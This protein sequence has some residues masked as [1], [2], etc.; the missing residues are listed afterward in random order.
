MTPEQ[1]V[2]ERL[3]R[4]IERRSRVQGQELSP[5]EREL[6]GLFEQCDPEAAGEAQR[7]RSSTEEL[8][9]ELLSLSPAERLDPRFHSDDLVELLLD[10]SEAA[11]VEDP[12]STIVW[13]DLALPITEAL[14]DKRWLASN[15]KVQAARLKGNA[16]RLQGDLAQAEAAFALAAIH[17]DDNSLERP[18]F[19][20]SLG[21]LRWEQ[22]RLDEAIGLFLHAGALFHAAGMGEE[23]ATTLL[24]LG[25]LYSETAFPAGGLLS[26][27][28]GFFR[29]SPHRHPWLSLC[30]GFALASHLGEIEQIAEGRDV[31]AKAMDLY[32]LVRKERC[33]LQGCRWE[34]AARVRLGESGQAEQLLEGVRRRHL[35]RR[36]LPE[37]ALTSL[38]LGAVLVEL[39]RPEEIQRLIEEIDHNFPT[40][41]GTTLAVQALQAFQAGTRRGDGARRS[42]SWAASDFRRLFRLLAI[43]LGPIPFT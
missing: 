34:G 13:A 30:S 15:G 24:L 35:A 23:E 6:L 9:D 31:L 33:L 18:W 38:D 10:E 3:A 1:R 37:L 41:Q 27:Y 40:D 26:L 29:A 28:E 17:L 4:E 5:G 2:L 42:A 36:D 22:H 32:A 39:G 11:Q 8:R 7:R 16:W 43:P 12:E 14:R 19:C 21:V 20:R 25:L